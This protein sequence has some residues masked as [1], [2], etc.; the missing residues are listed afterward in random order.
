MRAALQ[1][2]LDTFARSSTG[3]STRI[4]RAMLLF[5]PL[6]IDAGE[7]TDKG[8]LNQRAILK[9]REGLVAELYAASP[10]PRVIVTATKSA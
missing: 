6:S 1:T 5:E 8:S 10:G 7:L 9:N 2:R 3:S 4:A